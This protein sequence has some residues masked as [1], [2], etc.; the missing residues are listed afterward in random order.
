M[1]S[2]KASELHSLPNEILHPIKEIIADPLSCIVNLSFSEGVYFQNLKISKEIPFFKNKGNILE[3]ENY[4]PISLLSNM[5]KIIEKLMHE[6]LYNLLNINGC[7]YEN[8]FGFW[9]KHSAN[10]ALASLT[11]D[12]SSSLDKNEIFCGVCRDLQKAFDTVDYNL[13]L[14]ILNYYGI[15]GSANDWIKSFLTNRK[16]FM[17]INGHDTHEVDMLFCVPQASV[18]APLLFLI[19]INDLHEA[20]K[21]SKVRHFAHDTNLLINNKSP[22]QLQKQLNKDLCN[23][24]NWLKAKMQAKL[25]F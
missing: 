18:L 25:N 6:K 7:I 12:I 9:S 22:K 11:D 1:N 2:N 5:N 14:N 13:L 17:A 20:I 16:Q 19:Y 23:L 3:C 10:H 8:K 21:Y 15:R 4:R 24:C